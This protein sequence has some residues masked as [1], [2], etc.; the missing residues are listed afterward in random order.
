MWKYLLL[1]NILKISTLLFNE[2]DNIFYDKEE[3][4]NIQMVDAE[5]YA[6]VFGP[7]NSEDI[8]EWLSA[9]EDNITYHNLREQVTYQIWG[10]N[11]QMGDDSDNDRWYSSLTNYPSKFKSHKQTL[12][13]DEQHLW[14]SW[15]SGW[16]LRDYYSAPIKQR[17]LQQRNVR[18][19]HFYVMLQKII[20]KIIQIGTEKATDETLQNINLVSVKLLTQSKRNFEQA[21]QNLP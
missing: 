18:P 2:W 9:D 12:P 21:K 3:D 11:E 16:F 17:R 1:E 20:T 4:I 10:Q 6:C 14:H 19:L 15:S 7:T 13:D 8:R 5:G